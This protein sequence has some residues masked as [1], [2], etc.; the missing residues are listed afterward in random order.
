M[1]ARPLTVL[2]ESQDVPFTGERI[3]GKGSR[4]NL[5]IIVPQAGHSP[6]NNGE[7]LYVGACGLLLGLAKS[8]P[9]DYT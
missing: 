8:I 5:A 1:I 7:A 2:Q 9:E 3:L 6:G 4:T